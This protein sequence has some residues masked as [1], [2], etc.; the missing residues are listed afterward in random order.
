MSFLQVSYIVTASSTM[1]TETNY[2][3]S[4]RNCMNFNNKNNP[5]GQILKLQFILRLDISKPKSI[6]YLKV[7][8]LHKM[9]I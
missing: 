4:K 8:I 6:D 2:L 5:S 9:T 7:S 3:Y 1:K